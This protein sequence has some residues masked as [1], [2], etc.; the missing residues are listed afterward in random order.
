MPERSGPRYIAEQ[1][2]DGRWLVVDRGEHR[3]GRLAIAVVND[4]RTAQENADALST[5]DHLIASLPVPD[6]S[7]DP[8]FAEAERLITD[9]GAALDAEHN[10]NH[11]LAAP[12]TD[13]EQP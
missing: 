6:E 13:S 11:L 1:G 12:P 8:W 3:T 10:V 2:T 5:G 7:E 9:Y 4:E